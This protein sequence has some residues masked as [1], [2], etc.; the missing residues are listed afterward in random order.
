[1][2]D[3]MVVEKEGWSW[4]GCKDVSVHAGELVFWSWRACWRGCCQI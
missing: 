2:W 1:M 3:E 4:C